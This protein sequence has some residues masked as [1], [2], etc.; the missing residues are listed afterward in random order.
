MVGTENRYEG[1]K[2]EIIAALQRDIMRLEG[3]REKKDNGTDTGLGPILEAFPDATFPLGAVHE[4]LSAKPEDVAA[5]SGFITGLMSS[6]MGNNGTALWISS[7]RTLFPP[8]LKS[9]GI[10]PDRVI[11]IDLQNARQ[12]SWAMEEAL[13]CCALTVVVGELNE[14]DFTTSRRL[15]LAVEQSQVTGFILR[16]RYRTVQ[17]TACV[18][19]WKITSIASERID[20]LPGIGFPTWRVELLRVRNGKPGVWETTWKNGKFFPAYQPHIAQEHPQ[21]KTG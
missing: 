19:R 20:D 11:F 21:R 7:M 3:F 13:K 6:L 12:V 15:Q 8:A 17:T 5:T 2:A 9:F 1:K 4:F 10:E 18:S 14:V 16:N